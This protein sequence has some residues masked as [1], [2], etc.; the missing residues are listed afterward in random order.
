MTSNS[1]SSKTPP[2]HRPKSSSR[3]SSWLPGVLF[4]SA[5][6]AL[7][8]YF[9]RETVQVRLGDAVRQGDLNV[10]FSA[11]RRGANAND[12]CL[13]P[14]GTMHSLLAE[15]VSG[16][17][18]EIAVSLL[19]AGANPNADPVL[20]VALGGVSAGHEIVANPQ[21][22]SREH[23]AEVVRKAAV[24]DHLVHLLVMKG[25]NVNAV[26][27]GIPL[28][29]TAVDTK[30]LEIIRLLLDRGANPN[31]RVE[32]HETYTLGILPDTALKEAIERGNPQI[33]TLL[34]QH[35]AKT[36]FSPEKEGKT[37]LMFAAEAGNNEIVN[38][39]L[40]AGANPNVKSTRGLNALSWAKKGLETRK[41]IAAHFKVSPNPQMIQ[42]YKMMINTLSK[43]T[44]R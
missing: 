38:I 5:L 18:P 33:V 35:G 24:Y 31:L 36:D 43:Q 40:K 7:A 1:V 11:L 25:A 39:L 6:V 2:E 28:M 27:G 16:G 4:L 10:V 37:A 34:L 3:R 13:R 19:E 15:A 23:I 42:N 29:I 12:V 20:S 26:S 9:Y 32:G 21:N 30:N 22:W 14:D 17:H 41:G 8:F 44:R